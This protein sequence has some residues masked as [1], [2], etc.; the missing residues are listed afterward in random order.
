MA[1]FEANLDALVGPTHNYA[2]LGL[3]NKAST[4]NRGR[5]SNPRAAALQGL[6][7]MRRLHELGIAQLVMPPMPRPDLR[8]LR[9]F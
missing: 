6:E 1:R 4:R 9:Q 8:F 2:G 7:K 5:V 3:G